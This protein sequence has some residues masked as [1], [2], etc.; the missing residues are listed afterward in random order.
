MRAASYAVGTL[1]VISLYLI[2]AASMSF[3]PAIIAAGSVG[4]ALVAAIAFVAR[5]ESQSAA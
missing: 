4:I 5:N 3:A 2:V 1:I